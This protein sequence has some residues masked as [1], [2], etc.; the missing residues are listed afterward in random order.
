MKVEC[1]SCGR[2]INLGEWVF[3]DYEGPVKCFSC[4]R[5]MEVKTAQG[6][7]QS[8]TPLAI[9]KNRRYA[10]LGKTRD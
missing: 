5:M 8:L 3:D 2:E 7:V 9:L 6:I 10:T 4:S 1:V